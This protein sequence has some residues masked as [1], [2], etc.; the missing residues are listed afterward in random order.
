MPFIDLNEDVLTMFAEALYKIGKKQDLASFN[1][2]LG[3]T[4]STVAARWLYRDVERD[5]S[6]IE[7]PH[8]CAILKVLLT[9]PGYRTF[10]RSLTVTMPPTLFNLKGNV[11]SRYSKYILWL[12]PLLPGLH[13]FRY[14]Q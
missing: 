10:V 11:H 8:T 1:I 3:K 5:F 14:V 2:V 6:P 4:S 13:T 7:A 9:R 12:L